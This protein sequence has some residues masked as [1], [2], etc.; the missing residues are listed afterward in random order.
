MVNLICYTQHKTTFSAEIF[1]LEFLEPG[2]LQ[3]TGKPGPKSILYNTGTVVEYKKQ[4]TL[5]YFIT[6][7]KITTN[8][9]LQWM[10]IR[11]LLPSHTPLLSWT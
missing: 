10:K 8:E 9:R 7:R 3:N 1:V 6:K 2:N 4:I 5:G 11:M